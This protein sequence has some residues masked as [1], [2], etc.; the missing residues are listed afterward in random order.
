M[1]G[2]LFQKNRRIPEIE[3]V[4]ANCNVPF[5]SC[6]IAKLQDLILCKIVKVSSQEIGVAD[7]LETDFPSKELDEKLF[8]NDFHSPNMKITYEYLNFSRKFP[9]N[10]IVGFYCRLSNMKR[11]L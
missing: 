5:S 2:K 3:N 7:L 6:S 8:M 11:I 4:I 9:F 10:E 1:F